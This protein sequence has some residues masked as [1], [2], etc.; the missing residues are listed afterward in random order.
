MLGAPAAS[1]SVG[2]I[3]NII[4]TIYDYVI[5]PLK[6]GNALHARSE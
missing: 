4:I 3:K 6:T 1:V 5:S 2:T